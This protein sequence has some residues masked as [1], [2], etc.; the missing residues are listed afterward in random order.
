[1]RA[2][3]AGRFEA[4]VDS[5][6]EDADGMYAAPALRASVRSTPRRDKEI[7]CI[8][9]SLELN[10]MIRRLGARLL[11]MDSRRAPTSGILQSNNGGLPNGVVPMKSPEHALGQ[12]RLKMF[13]ALAQSV[14]GCG[15]GSGPYAPA[16]IGI[17]LPVQTVT[18]T[19]NGP[20]V[21][22]PIQIQSTSETAL[23]SVQGL[24]A[25]VSETYAA[26]DTNP[27]GTLAFAATRTATT[28]SFTAR[29]SVMSAGQTATAGFTIIVRMS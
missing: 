25:G 19:Q 27:S 10:L 9:C 24:P 26:S 23:V 3:G 20:A 21:I 17:Y 22:I 1:L 8:V 6:K 7:F 12:L 14:A 5:A 2:E 11:E 29:V 18:V 16:P 28:G 15:G 4:K 13:C